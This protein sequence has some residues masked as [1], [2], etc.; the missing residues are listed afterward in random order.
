M[1]LASGATTAQTVSTT[2]DLSAISAQEGPT[3]FEQLN[4][5]WTGFC[6]KPPAAKEYV[7]GRLTV[8]VYS[9]ALRPP[10]HVTPTQLLGDMAQQPFGLVNQLKLK[11]GWTNNRVRVQR[12]HMRLKDGKPA[13]CIAWM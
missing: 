7:M 5:V 9:A 13:C 1:S 3:A 6:N 8:I 11:R 12:G 2:A 4:A 10:Q